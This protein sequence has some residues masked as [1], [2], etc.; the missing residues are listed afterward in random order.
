MK[1][2]WE[3]SLVMYPINEMSTNR[4]VIHKTNYPL[5]NQFRL[6]QDILK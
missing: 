6:L 4:G 2:F 3:L 5:L 1:E